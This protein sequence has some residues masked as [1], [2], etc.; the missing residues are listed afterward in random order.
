MQGSTFLTYLRIP[1]EECH[2]DISSGIAPVT[3]AN[4]EK[5]TSSEASVS[6]PEGAGERV[7]QHD[8][9]TKSAGEFLKYVKEIVNANVGVR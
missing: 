8:L 7:W 9:L 5:K 2:K 1:H 6:H 4:E 3:I